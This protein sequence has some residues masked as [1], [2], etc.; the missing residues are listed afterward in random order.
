MQPK[1]KFV[2]FAN[3]KYTKTSSKMDFKYKCFKCGAEFNE[4]K[5]IISHL[6]VIHFIKDNSEPIKCSVGGNYCPMVFYKFSQLKQHM[7]KCITQEKTV[8]GAE[9]AN[10]D[11]ELEGTFGDFHI[12]TNVKTEKNSFVIK[13]SLCDQVSVPSKQNE[14]VFF[15]GSEA[16]NCN[17][18]DVT[19]FIDKINDQLCS[20]QLNH[21]Q[22]D[23][24]Y[25]TFL[26][27]M[28]N[29][30][31]FNQYF[32]ENGL[33]PAEACQFSIKFIR[34]KFSEC[35]SRYKRDQMFESNEF[36]VK[37]V[38]RTLGVRWTNLQMPNVPEP[39]PRLIQNVFYK[40]PITQ[41]IISL[42][43]RDD[44]RAEYIRYN[45]EKIKNVSCGV[46][47]DFS[48]GTNFKTNEL[49]KNYPN[50][51]QIGIG[52]DDFEPCNSLGS[53]ATIHK[54]SPVYVTIK[55][56]PPR[57]ASK[58]CNIYL[59]SLCYSD[60][61]KTKFND[62]NDI[63]H[64]LMCDVK[65]IENGIE[66]DAGE[67]IKG[68]VVD[69]DSDNLGANTILGFV[70]N[71]SKTENYCRFCVCTREEAQKLCREIPS[72]RR[73]KEQYDEQIA[74][75][76]NSTKVDFKATQG[77][78]MYC[79]LN[80]LKYFNIIESM[81]PDIM[82]DV[83]EGAIPF[84]LKHLFEHLIDKKVCTETEL[85]NKIKY[86]NYGTMNRNNIPSDLVLNKSN[87][88][89]NASQLQCLFQHIPFILHDYRD[90]N[91]LQAVWVCVESLLR[92]TQ[93]IYSTKIEESD[94]QELEN[95]IEVHLEQIQLMF[96]V[97]LLPKHHFMTHYA[98]VIRAMGALIQFSMKRYEAK[99]KEVKKCIGDS[100]NFKNLT[101]TITERHQQMMALK[102]QTYTD[103][104]RRSAVVKLLDP[105][106]IVLQKALLEEKID[107]GLDVNEVKFLDYNSFRYSK[108]FFVVS[109]NFLHR[110]EK[111][112]INGSEHYF[113][114]RRF[115]FEKFDS[116]LNSIK[117][118]KF[119]PDL[120]EVIKF[121]SMESKN[122]YE[123]TIFNSEYHIILKTLDLKN[124]YI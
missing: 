56:I 63:W 69:A 18:E 79:A 54:L 7:K 12:S 103:E 11:F 90:S 52:Q 16:K 2:C 61:L 27:L 81:T 21:S 76:A 42:F 96:N 38:V 62:W 89:Q 74:L 71:F 44:F 64:E 108:G 77:V 73:T 43:R 5:Y 65:Q 119:E 105:E 124:I 6:K 37:P 72:K 31:S 121:S 123:A 116:F 86:H 109:G 104:F 10:V 106:F 39:I 45:E 117:I 87:L 40:I 92:I 9:T 95:L 26:D 55:N 93:I 30:E 53:K 78:A 35:S 91:I 82:H 59:A 68:T 36:Y 17:E 50:S 99:H 33:S 23:N 15:C 57:F 20:L 13:Q 47:S 118:K 120:F 101:K 110:I 67:E 34:A 107:F 49:F 115:A 3:E 14:N 84:L 66:L 75:I 29:M 100:N 48:S 98:S 97:L 94:L 8:C 46:Y 1:L 51:L 80:D 4:E 70:K 60:D 122:T 22:M 85:I 83:N 111:V 25:Q 58:L 24:V 19:S 102:T 32:I 113:F 112:L 41:T 28:D 88:G 114:C